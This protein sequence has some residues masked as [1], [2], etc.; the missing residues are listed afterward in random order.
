M[1]PPKHVVQVRCLFDEPVKRTLAEIVAASG[2]DYVK[3][4]TGFSR[5]GA[6]LEDV[7]LLKDSVAGH[8]KVK[9]AG[10]IRDLATCQAMMAAGAD[11]IGTSAGVVIVQQWLEKFGREI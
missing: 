6:T 5:S 8:V 1:H 9:A 2:A 4:S 3:T 7:A 10:G 11:R